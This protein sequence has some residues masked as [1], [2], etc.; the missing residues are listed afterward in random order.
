MIYDRKLILAFSICRKG[1]DSEIL[2]HTDICFVQ[3]DIDY[4]Y[5]LDLWGEKKK[6]IK[7]AFNHS[8]ESKFVSVM[9]KKVIEKQ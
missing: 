9:P 1:N 6:F 5:W 3:S 7:K 2:C 4:E 8:T